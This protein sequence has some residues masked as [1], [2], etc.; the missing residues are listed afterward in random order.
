MLLHRTSTM[1]AR[2]EGGRHLT[3]LCK[4]P[5]QDLIVFNKYLNSFIAIGY[6]VWK[7][8]CVSYYSDPPS[9]TKVYYSVYL[10]WRDD[11][12]VSACIR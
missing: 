1:H 12:F 9:H 5:V 2:R 10:S 11:E 3:P 7:Y 4:Y 6:R 8:A